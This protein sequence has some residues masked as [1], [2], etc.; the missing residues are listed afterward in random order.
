MSVCSKGGKI[1]AV[2]M[3]I[4][5]LGIDVYCHILCR[6]WFGCSINNTTANGNGI[7]RTVGL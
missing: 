7:C 4:L 3:V 2:Q 5:T 6:L 1:E